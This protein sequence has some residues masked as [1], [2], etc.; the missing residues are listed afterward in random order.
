MVAILASRHPQRLLVA[1][2][3]AGLAFGLVVRTLVGRRRPSRAGRWRPASAAS[4]YSP[5]W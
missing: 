5:P 4:G 2:I 1:Y 3:V